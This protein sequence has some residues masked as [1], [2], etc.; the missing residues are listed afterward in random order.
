MKKIFIFSNGT[1][2]GRVQYFREVHLHMENKTYEEKGHLPITHCSSK[3][4][5]HQILKNIFSKTMLLLLLRL[6]P[7]VATL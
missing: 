4:N 7:T 3:N 5:L 6:E 1:P 2:L